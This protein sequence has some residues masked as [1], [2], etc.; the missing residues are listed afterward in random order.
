[1]PI[2]GIALVLMLCSQTGWAGQ[3][4][5]PSGSTITGDVIASGG[6]FITSAS[7]SINGTIGQFAVGRSTAGSGAALIHGVHGPVI[8]SVGPSL[9]AQILGPSTVIK[10][11]GESHTFEVSVS[12][13]TGNIEYQWLF[14][15]A[16]KA[17]DPI[18]GADSSTLT[19]TDL[20]P[21]DA[22]LYRCEVSD[23]LDTVQSPP[24]SL[25][26]TTGMSLFEIPQFRDVEP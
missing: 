13:A 24:V 10:S 12:G 8:A 17:F 3:R 4:N 6:A 23:D 9:S 20:G 5:A 1:L 16:T 26:V 2:L 15:S 11:V 7:G 21:E 18:L 14:E 25:T 19:I 22:G